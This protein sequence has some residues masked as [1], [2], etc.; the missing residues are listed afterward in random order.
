M[1]T[2]AYSAFPALFAFGHEV[3]ASTSPVLLQDKLGD[4]AAAYSFRAPDFRSAMVFRTLIPAD[5]CLWKRYVSNWQNLL[6]SRR[7]SKLS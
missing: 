7:S 4:F 3:E 5:R 2:L 1:G 6:A